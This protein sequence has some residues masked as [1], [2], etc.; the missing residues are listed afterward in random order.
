VI[1]NR[2]PLTVTYW[3]D[4]GTSIHREEVQFYSKEFAD[5]FIDELAELF[6]EEEVTIT[7]L[8]M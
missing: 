8:T 6:A 2:K 3:I 7:T 1:D 5:I 4:N